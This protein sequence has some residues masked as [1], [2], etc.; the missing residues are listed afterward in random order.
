MFPE[1]GRLNVGIEEERRPKTRIRLFD[2]NNSSPIDVRRERP[3]SEERVRF[4]LLL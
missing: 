1:N 2:K 4:S 3:A